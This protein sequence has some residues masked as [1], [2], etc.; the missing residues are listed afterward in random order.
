MRRKSRA[1]AS[2]VRNAIS[3]IGTP[4]M[5]RVA[6]TIT[7]LPRKGESVMP[8]V[9]VPSEC[10]H[11]SFGVSLEEVLSHLRA[12]RHQDVG[13][14]GELERLVAGADG[15]DRQLGMARLEIFLV[16]GAGRLGMGEEDEE[17]HWRT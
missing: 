10:T 5:P 17:V 6:V 4:W 13:P 9:P 3:E 7:S 1:N 12:E 15:R 11:F 14:G 8:S 16:A 2:I